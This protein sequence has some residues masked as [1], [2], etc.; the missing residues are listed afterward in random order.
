MPT[1]DDSDGVDRDQDGEPTVEP[2]VHELLLARIDEQCRLLALELEQVAKATDQLEP[3][4]AR[5]CRNAI[6]MCSGDGRRDSPAVPRPPPRRTGAVRRRR[7]GLPEDCSGSAS[8]IPEQRSPGI[9]VGGP[10]RVGVA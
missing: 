8:T 3:E 7:A 5:S 6:T 4:G 1:S 10:L 9:P 2:T